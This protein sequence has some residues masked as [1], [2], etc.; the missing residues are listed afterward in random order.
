MLTCSKVNL[1][2]AVTARRPDG[3]HDLDS[4]FYPFRDP[5]DEITLEDAPAA[6]G[7]TIRCDAPGVPLEP[8]KNLCGKAVYAYCKA[9]GMD[10]PGLIIHLEKHI[11]VAAGMGG[12][13]A[14]C[15][16]M[17]R[18]LQDRFHEL[19]QEQL[20]N[21]A[22]SLGADVPFFL[23]PRPSHVTGAGEHHTPI[24]GLPEHLPLL[25]AAPQF[26]VS[27]AWAYQHM[28]LR[29]AISTPPQTNELIDA[30]RR[31]D[32]ESAAHFMRNDLE[33][34]LFIKYPLLV[35]LRRFLLEN[36]AIRAMVS[37]SGP[38]LLALFRDDAAAQA[39]YARAAAEFASRDS[40]DAF[41]PERQPGT[42][43]VEGLPSAVR[44]LLPA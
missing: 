3:Y 28:D 34:A 31:R 9:A 2:L 18:L 7:V 4:L 8:E 5:S 13:S 23:N 29:R 12:G 36:G 20:E 38:T 25:L 11:P 41:V 14:D 24:G 6:S 40:R 42:T 21:V 19:S 17:L 10:I 39:A 44:F 16:T 22:F 27:A 26:P 33:H 43:A 15:A 30:L 1:S 35:L 37:G 32:Y